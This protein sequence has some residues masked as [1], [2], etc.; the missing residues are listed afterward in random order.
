MV[1]L[2]RLIMC[3]SGKLSQAGV[4]SCVLEDHVF[5][6]VVVEGRFCILFVKSIILMLQLSL[7][8]S[9]ELWGFGLGRKIYGVIDF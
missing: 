1:V 7:Y 2:G 5:R 9:M 3:E 6:C 8:I 4:A